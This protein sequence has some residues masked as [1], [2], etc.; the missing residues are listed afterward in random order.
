MIFHDN[1]K[2]ITLNKDSLFNWPYQVYDADYPK[3]LCPYF[4]KTLAMWISLPFALMIAIATLGMVGAFFMLFIGI[5][6]EIMTYKHYFKYDIS[7]SDAKKY[8]L[9]RLNQ[10]YELPITGE[11]LSYKFLVPFSIILFICTYAVCWT[12]VLGSPASWLWPLGFMGVLALTGFGLGVS[13]D[14]LASSISRPYAEEG[15]VPYRR[16]LCASTKTNNVFWSFI[17]AK[18]NKVCPQIEWL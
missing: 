11:K 9:D 18:Y 15:Y 16:S 5:A 3:N 7:M 12:W 6:F 10:R 13:V 4:W 17:K 1:N 8:A 2:M 14:V